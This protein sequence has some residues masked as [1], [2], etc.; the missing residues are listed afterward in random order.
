MA[1]VLTATSQIVHAEQPKQPKFQ[2]IQTQFI[3]ALGDPTASSGTGAELWGLWKKDPGPRGVSL[4]S[5]ERVKNAGGVA[6]AGWKFDDSDWYVEEHGLIMEKPTGGDGGSGEALKPGQYLVT[7]DRQITTVLTISPPDSNGALRWELGKGKL[8]DVT[9]LPC[10]TGRYSGPSCTPAK[11]RQSDF[12]VPPGG[13]MPPV[14]GCNKLDY[15]VIFVI[16]VVA[17]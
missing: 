15:A 17:S 8:Y 6:R 11:A 14:E 9:H 10:R 3:A 1:P 7:G 12:P 4:D 16:G 5:I 2:R 13:L